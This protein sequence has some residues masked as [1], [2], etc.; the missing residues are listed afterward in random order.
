M[1]I[2]HT[3]KYTNDSNEHVVLERARVHAV[4]IRR[5]KDRT[6]TENT[7]NTAKSGYN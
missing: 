2:R 3:D 4:C 7:T 1:T 6:K 5:T